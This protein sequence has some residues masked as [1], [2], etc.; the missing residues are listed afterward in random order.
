MGHRC[1]FCGVVREDWPCLNGSDTRN[2]EHRV[3]AVEKSAFGK[4]DRCG[5]CGKFT[6]KDGRC[7]KVFT[8]EPGIYEHA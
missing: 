2:C 6:N 3:R 5:I 8:V 1:T 7:S 4:R